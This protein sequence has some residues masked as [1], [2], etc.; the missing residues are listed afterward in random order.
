ML[1]KQEVFDFISSIK[2][3]LRINELDLARECVLQPLLYEEVSFKASIARSDVNRYKESMENL[4]AKLD[5]DIR[6]NPEEFGLSGKVTENSISNTIVNNESFREAKEDYLDALEIS[7]SLDSLLRT[8]E[9]RKSM[10]RDLV[11]LYIFQYYSSENAK[12]ISNRDVKDVDEAAIV[13]ARERNRRRRRVLEEDGAS[14][15]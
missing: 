5:I 10:L 3:R 4:R 13:D 9:Q 14:N 1:D 2:S 15:G 6:T 11:Q 12:P 7:G 8:V